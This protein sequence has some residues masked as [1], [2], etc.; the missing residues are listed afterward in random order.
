ML[1]IRHLVLICLLIVVSLPGGF[2]STAKAQTTNLL[3]NGSMEEPYF[4][5]GAPTRTV[6]Q[7]WNLSVLAGAP[8]AF[9]HRDPLTIPPHQGTAAWNIKQG[10]VA[11][12]AVAYQRVSGLKAGSAV[13]FGAFGWAYTC[14]D[15]TN[16]CIIEAAPYRR[17]DSSAGVSMKVGIDPNGGT[18]PNAASI[19][20]SA[21]VAPYDQWAEMSVSAIPAGDAVTVFMYASQARGLAMNNVY[22]DDASLSGTTGGT[23]VPGATAV[24]PTAAE[25]P[26]VV[27]QN[28]RPDGSI[29]HVVQAG[30]T[31]SS[32][33]F[34]YRDYGVTNESIAS[35]NPGMQPNSR[36]LLLGQEVVVLPPGSVDPA[37][38][39]LVTGGG[40]GPRPTGTAGATGG[41]TTPR[42]PSQST[43]V[44]TMTPFNNTNNTAASNSNPPTI[45]PI[46]TFITVTPAS[47]LPVQ[48]MNSQS[49]ESTEEVAEVLATEEVVADA[50][51][52]ETLAPTATTEVVEQAATEEAIQPTAVVPTIAASPT[53][54]A[55][56]MVT[57][58]TLCL[59]LYEDTNTNQIYDEGELPLT[60]ASYNLGLEGETI[61]EYD[62]DPA[63]NCMDLEP[64][65]YDVTA[66]A[67]ADFGLT[68]SPTARVT[69]AS[70][71]QVSVSFGGARGYVAPAAP[72]DTTD[73]SSETETGAVAPIVEEKVDSEDK[74]FLDRL[75]DNSG[76]IV[77]GFAGVVLIVSGALVL[78]LRRF[79][80]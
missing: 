26:F 69:L 31:L 9:P 68:T 76:L 8:D 29:V 59:N 37:T 21:V 22:W 10:Y 16:S 28:V 19:Q 50:V 20:W 43:R 52:T 53:E 34:A 1:K 73:L 18:D 11:F 36:F 15:T 17:S 58:G 12:T 40:S 24:P 49:A 45:T 62:Y 65:F 51:A 23:A 32:I 67:P 2:P 42:P 3:V 80:H 55:V 63:N 54:M 5:Q 39:R 25:V 48:P 38:G 77:L 56:A 66:L 64:G 71:R 61:A 41:Q 33:A 4:G 72:A 75:Y 44:P 6:P 74:S 14:N 60:G 79:S 30:D 70:G 27:A 46:P 13:R 7:G 35:N 57:T 78:A 47:V